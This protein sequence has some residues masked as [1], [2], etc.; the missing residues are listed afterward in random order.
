MAINNRNPIDIVHD[1]EDP[2]NEEDPEII[3]ETVDMDDICF[4]FTL[5]T[6][7]VQCYAKAFFKY[8]NNSSLEA[9]YK[10]SMSATSLAKAA[11]SYIDINLDERSLK[12]IQIS[13]HKYTKLS[14]Y[15]EN[16]A[17]DEN[18]KIYSDSVKLCRKYLLFI[19]KSLQIILEEELEQE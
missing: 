9:L 16:L 2:D 4:E 17:Q 6:Q 18:M 10:K 7:A 13:S 12:A 3:D 15:I 8:S 1:P 11:S 5:A 14:E 19:E